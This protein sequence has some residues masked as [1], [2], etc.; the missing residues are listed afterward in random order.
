MPSCCLVSCHFEFDCY[1]L[2]FYLINVLLWGYKKISLFPFS[3]SPSSLAIQS[4]FIAHR[5]IIMLGKPEIG[6]TFSRVFD[7]PCISRP[8]CS[9]SFLYELRFHFL[10]S[11]FFLFSFLFPSSTGSSSTQV[12]L[13]EPCISR[14]PSIFSVYNKLVF[15]FFPFLFFLFPFFPFFPFLSFI[16]LHCYDTE[17]YFSNYC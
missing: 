1:L 6:S 3:C 10:F 7:K 17:L 11:L 2:S 12:S 5:P 8:S 16:I 4:R 14:S 13:Y 9:F 15:R